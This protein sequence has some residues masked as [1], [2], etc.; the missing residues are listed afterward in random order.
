AGTSAGTNDYPDDD[1]VGSNGECPS[2]LDQDGDADCSSSSGGDWTEYCE[3]ESGKGD[4]L[5]LHIAHG[6]TMTKVPICKSYADGEVEFDL[7]LQYDSRR[8]YESRPEGRVTA[9]GWS[10]SYGL[11][12]WGTCGLPGGNGKI[13]FFGPDGRRNRFEILGF[14][15]RSPPGRGLVAS[16][17]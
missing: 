5:H 11:S 7:T 12:I 16:G 9:P 3:I 4:G 14:G 2:Q 1:E 13:I 17:G 10:H 15:L 6:A 8:A